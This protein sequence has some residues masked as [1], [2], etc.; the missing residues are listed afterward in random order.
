MQVWNLV[1][2]AR[3][4]YRTQ[5]WRKKS[6]SRHHCTTLSGYIFAVR[7]V[8]TI[9]KKV[10]KHQYLLQMSSQYSKLRP[11][12]GWDQL[13]GLGHP[14]KFQWVSR[15]GFV[16]A[17]RCSPEANQTLH[18]VWSSPGLVHY[19]YTFRG[20]CSLMEFCPMQ[21][22]LYV[23]LLQFSYIG[24]VTAHH[25]SSGNQPN[26]AAWYR[27]WNYWTFAEGGAPPIFGWAAITLGIGHILVCFW[28][29]RF[30]FLSTML[31]DWLGRTRFNCLMLLSKTDIH[32]MASFSGQPG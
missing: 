6:P 3:W 5:K 15:L 12:S 21:N 10:V 30:S 18:D 2:A 31:S 8:A 4:K 23:Q 17:A 20:C 9:G 11:T 16:I 7:H 19:V 24:S 29:V 28:R 14:S 13:A 25:S 1:H 27:E 22:I 32:L 26:S